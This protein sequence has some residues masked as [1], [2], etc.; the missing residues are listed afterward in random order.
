VA[1]TLAAIV[2]PIPAFGLDRQTIMDNLKRKNFS[3]W[4]GVAIACDLS[5]KDDSLNKA[6]CVWVQ[7]KVRLLAASARIKVI[8]LDSN[9]AFSREF[10]FELHDHYLPLTIGMQSSRQDISI[11]LAGTVSAQPY[12]DWKRFGESDDQRVR[13]GSLVVWDKTFVA[14]GTLSSDFDAAVQQAFETRLMEFFADYTEGANT[15]NPD[16]PAPMQP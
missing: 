5:P 1:F 14:A 15:A 4:E 6:T 7:Q 3:G 16:S 13:S 11:A 12:G 2:L 10:E 8:V 9:D